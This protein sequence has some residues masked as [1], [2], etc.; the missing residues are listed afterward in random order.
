MSVDPFNYNYPKLKHN[1]SRRDNVARYLAY[2]AEIAKDGTCLRRKVGAVIVRSNSVLATGF[3]GSPPG[4][5]HC[6]DKYL[7][8][9]TAMWL[10][11]GC[12]LENDNEG[13]PHCVRT[14]HAEHNA[15]LQAARNGVSL[16]G[17]TLYT[18]TQPCG[19]C[20]MILRT[21][22]IVESFYPDVVYVSQIKGIGE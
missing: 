20:L 3:N 5:P 12:L 13:N 7:A 4:M 9:N 1:E 11:V 15:I 10:Q 6:D 14:I 17:S 8:P 2:A 22:S 21:V 19:S 18:T 16:A